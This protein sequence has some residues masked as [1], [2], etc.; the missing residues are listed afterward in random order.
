MS[1]AANPPLNRSA[2]LGYD[3]PEPVIGG[4]QPSEH[5]ADR[6]RGSDMDVSGIGSVHH[7]A[8]IARAQATQQASLPAETV[9][10]STEDQVEISAAA[11]LLDEAS[12]ISG[13]R[14]ERLQAIKAA[15]EAGTY[16]TDVKL[17][18]ALERMI[19]E[20]GFDERA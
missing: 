13:V 8:P 12:A 3:T 18:A 5:P 7:S 4:P 10:I 17:E 6:P 19:N 9:R 20:I 1:S 14:A 11:R 2:W 15:I 16:D